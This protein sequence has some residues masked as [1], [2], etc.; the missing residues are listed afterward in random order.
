MAPAGH[1]PDLRRVRREPDLPADDRYT[2]VYDIS[3]RT[4]YLPDGTRSEA[5]S[6]YGNKLDDPRYVN[7]RM[8]G[9]TPPQRL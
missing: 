8:V 2:A 5:H 9:P 4:V 3:A 6:G 1:S 7:E